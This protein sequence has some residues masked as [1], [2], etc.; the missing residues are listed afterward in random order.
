MF[1]RPASAAAF[2]LIFSLQC[3]VGHVTA[4]HVKCNMFVVDFCG[5]R[6]NYREKIKNV[7]STAMCHQKALERNAKFF[8]YNIPSW[9]ERGT[10]SLCYIFDIS[11]EEFYSSCEMFYGPVDGSRTECL[12][13]NT[14]CSGF[15]HTYMNFLAG[16]H[17]YY[18]FLDGISDEEACQKACLYDDKCGFYDYYPPK[19]WC[20]FYANLNWSAG[21]IIGEDMNAD[22]TSSLCSPEFV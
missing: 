20:A 16:Q 6:D 12:A 8:I 15:R 7:P 22:Y 9:V 19:S 14:P 10:N 13:Q 5:M 21:A 18:S 3:L 4:Q 2:G 17:Q 11:L 1:F